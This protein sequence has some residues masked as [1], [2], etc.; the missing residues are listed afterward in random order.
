MR[1]LKIKALSFKISKKQKKYCVVIDNQNKNIVCNLN[2]KQYLIDFDAFYHDLN[3][4]FVFNQI[5]VTMK[6][7]K[8][9]PQTKIF[10]AVS[11][12]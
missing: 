12:N 3:L 10:D 2:W 1:S 8:N 7:I 9:Y 5:L 11:T 6:I 4:I